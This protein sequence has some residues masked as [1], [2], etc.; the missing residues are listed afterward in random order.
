M[1]SSRLQG[2]V[3]SAGF[4]SVVLVSVVKE[5]PSGK[6]LDVE[7]ALEAVEPDFRAPPLESPDEQ[8]QRKDSGGVPPSFSV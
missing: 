7:P 6:M 4:V 5:M 2:L 8:P 1:V 3:G